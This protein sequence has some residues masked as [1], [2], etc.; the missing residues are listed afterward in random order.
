MNTLSWTRRTSNIKDGRQLE[1]IHL[2]SGDQTEQLYRENP[3]A[4]QKS[5][6][7]VFTVRGWIWEILGLVAATISLIGAA[8][9]LLFYSD[10]PAP[11]WQ[12]GLTLNAVLSIAATL[13]RGGL[14]VPIAAGISQF[15]WLRFEHNTQPLDKICQH[16]NASR[17]PMGSLLFLRKSN[18][19]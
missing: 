14:A 5:F 3:R 18:L 9:L 11:K 8:A 10:K 4:T 16:D 13:Y 6:L 17:G 12:A 15:G 19:A 1:S 2:V 7:D